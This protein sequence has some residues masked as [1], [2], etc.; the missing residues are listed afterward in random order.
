MGGVIAFATAWTYPEVFGA[1]MSLSP[2]F[3]LEG[4]MDTLPWFE[5]R[6]GDEVRPVF[7]YLDSGGQG[8]DA[9]LRPGIEDMVDLL[10]AWGYRPERNYVFVRDFDA[11]HGVAAWGQRFPNALTRSLRGSERLERLPNGAGST[12]PNVASLTPANQ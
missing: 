5:E 6:V 1:A 7:F 8:A 4:R 11:D 2:A 9:L 10:Q 12:V 3:R